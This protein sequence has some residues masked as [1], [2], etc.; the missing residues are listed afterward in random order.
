MVFLYH[1]LEIRA[2]NIKRRERPLKRKRVP[3]E[4]E[5]HVAHYSCCGGLRRS[6][7]KYFSTKK[8]KLQSKD[9]GKSPELLLAVGLRARLHGG[10]SSSRLAAGVVV[11]FSRCC[12][13]RTKVPSATLQACAPIRR[14][15]VVRKKRSNTF[16]TKLASRCT[17]CSFA[18]FSWP[19]ATQQDCTGAL[20]FVSDLLLFTSDALFH[21]PDRASVEFCDAPLRIHFFFEVP[22]TF[23][24]LA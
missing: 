12:G 7:P 8:R 6:V 15:A 24:Y 11:S 23:S 16:C 14:Q 9:T 20:K 22:L 18:S 21:V 2:K 10:H 4:D 5:V 19:K 1:K 17:V 3:K 13:V